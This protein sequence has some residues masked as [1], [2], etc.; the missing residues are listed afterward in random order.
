[1]RVSYEMRKD[2]INFAL[3]MNVFI[4]VSGSVW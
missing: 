2:V 4:Y 1:M 3:E